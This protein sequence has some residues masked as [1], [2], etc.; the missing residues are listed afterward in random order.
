MPESNVLRFCARAVSHANR[1]AHRDPT[2]P[3]LGPGHVRVSVL[4][5]AALW[6]ASLPGCEPAELTLHRDGVHRDWDAIREEGTLRALVV[7]SSTSYFLYRGRPMGYEYEL[8]RQMATDL[9]LKLELVI[10]H[11]ID[12]LGAMLRRGEGDVIAYGMTVTEERRQRL[13]FTEHL[14]LTRQ[15]LVQRKPE[16]WKSM[17]PA[18]LEERLIRDPAQLLGD[19]V[20]VRQGSAHAARLKDMQRELGG[21]LTE[22]LV[23]GNTTTERLMEMVAAGAIR[24]TLADDNIAKTVA[25][26]H[27]DL[28]VETPLSITQRVG[29]AVRRSSPQLLDTLNLWIRTHR[30]TR[31]HQALFAKYFDN[32]R[33]Y[34]ARARSP[35]LSLNEGRISTY[36]EW[37]KRYAQQQDLDWRLISAVI[38]EESGFNPSDTSWAGARGL[39]QLMPTTAAELGIE[40]PLD[41][42]SSIRGGTR[43]LRTLI[44]QWSEIPD[45]LDR[46][47]FALASYN[48]GLAHVLDARRLAEKHGADTQTWVGHVETYLLQLS[49]P[50]FYNDEVVRYG[51]IRG[52]LA[53]NY[54]RS[55]MSHYTHYRNLLPYAD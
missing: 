18:E 30:D 44:D 21:D 8:M 53:V 32:H 35:Y 50:A 11:H 4:L 40:D 23:A 51:Y 31:A 36:D 37:V 22:V 3:K 20:T 10:A 33:A 45:S 5:V 14:Y 1:P 16:G 6:A 49:D 34:R 9:D 7:Y 55:V 15:M 47:Q 27:S 38:M 43:Y 29:F 52:S 39:M 41:P 46:I 19:T 12:S 13:A 42:E 28:D 25:A 54:V 17:R 48:V 2:R 24:Y 26:N